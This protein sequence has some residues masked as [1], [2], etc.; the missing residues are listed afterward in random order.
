MRTPD[1]T[2]GNMPLMSVGTKAL[3]VFLGCLPR[4]SVEV[5]RKIHVE[6]QAIMCPTS[7]DMKQDKNDLFFEE[8]LSIGSKR[9]RA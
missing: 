6:R 5:D 7:I 2:Q 9:Q 4:Q 8:S 1:Q 3:N